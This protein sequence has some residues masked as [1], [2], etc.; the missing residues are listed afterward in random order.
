MRQ[1]Q[2]DLDPLADPRLLSSFGAERFAA[3]AEQQREVLEEAKRVLRETPKPGEA[4]VPDVDLFGDEWTIDRQR[5]LARQFIAKI[6]LRRAV[7]YGRGAE[8]IGERLSITWAG[9]DERDATLAE[10]V[11]R[12]REEAEPLDHL[13]SSRA[14]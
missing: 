7:G 2:H 4:V 9:H 11:Q 3:M 5:A 6:A 12:L 13:L 14:A 1:P 8:P 10:R